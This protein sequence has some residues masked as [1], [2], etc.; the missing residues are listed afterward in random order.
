[1]DEQA[2]GVYDGASAAFAEEWDGQPAPTDL[3]ETVLAY[4]TPGATADIGC[5]SGR[6]AAWLSANGFPTVGYDPSAGLL[7][8]AR[9]LHSEVE[10]R[11]AA[12][13]E[14]SGVVEHGHVNV[15]CETVIMHL[16]PRM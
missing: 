16:R 5:G 6:D 10:F 4:F 9:R 8:E 15:L 12:L 2:P 13:P 3:R 14:L 11:Q 7:G 1:V